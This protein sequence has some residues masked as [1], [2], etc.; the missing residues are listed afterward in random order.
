MLK[1]KRLVLILAVFLVCMATSTVFAQVPPFGEENIFKKRHEIRERIEQ[2]RM[3][4][5]LEVLDLSDEK[6]EKFLPVFNAFQREQKGLE[7]RKR[8]IL[9]ELE[10]E[11]DK[12]KVDLKK[13]QSSLD[14]LEQNRILF[15][16]NTVS[17]LSK[18]KEVLSLEQQARL[19]LFEESFADRVKDMIRK[20]RKGRMGMEG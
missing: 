4:R 19:V 7:K 15:E 9:K 3:W 14:D 17:F 11:L 18:A 16:N 1:L 8:G 6:A 10:D 20:L 2:M 13:V 12:E 5:L